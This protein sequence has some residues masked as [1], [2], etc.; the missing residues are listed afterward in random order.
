MKQ[1]LKIITNKLLNK[2]LKLSLA[3]LMIFSYINHNTIQNVNAVTLGYQSES[4][5]EKSVTINDLW[6]DSSSH[7]YK[8]KMGGEYGFCLDMGQRFS[9]GKYY[10]RNSW[11]GVRESTTVKKIMNWFYRGSKSDYHFWLAQTAIWGIQ[12]GKITNP[13]DDFQKIWTELDKV[14][15]ALY[16]SLAPGDTVGPDCSDMMNASSEGSFYIYTY[17][18]GYQRVASNIKGEIPTASGKLVFSTKSYSTT[19]QIQLNINKTDIDTNNVLS[20]VEFELYR[21]NTKIANVKTNA[22]GKASH[23]FE[24]EY[25]KTATA[26][27]TYCDNYD[28]LS[29]KNKELIGEVDYTSRNAAQNAADKEA[30]DKAKAEVQKLLD[31][32]HSYKAVE[33]KTKTAYYLDTNNNTW[34]K[35]YASGD[36]S[37]S[38]S[39]SVTNKRQ[40]G[41]ISI[42][43]LDSETGHSVSNAIYGLYAKNPIVHPDGHTGTLYAKDELVATFPATA[44]NG[45]ATLNNLYLGDY[46]VKEITAPNGYVFNTKKY[47]VTLSYAGQEISVTDES[48]NVDDKVQR[49]SLSFVKKD[50]ELVNGKDEN[51]FDSN[52]DG[53]QGDATRQHATYGLYA[54]ENIVHSDGTT[55]IVQYNQSSGSINEIKLSKGTDLSVKNVRANAGVLLATAKTDRNGEIQFDHLYNGKYYVKEIE[56]SEGYL[57]DHTE[58]DFDL[59]YTNQSEA[60]IKKDGTVLETVKKQAFEVLKVGHVSGSSTVVPPLE[61]VEF[62]VKLESDVVRLGWDNAPTY[63]ILVTDEKGHARSIELPSGTY[64]VKETKPAL[65]YD[66]CEDF[67]VTISEDSRT[68]QS[69]TNKII[70]DEAF[71]A[72]IKAVKLDK[73]TGKTVMLPDTTFKIKALSDVVVDGKSFKAGEYIGY[74]NWNILDG[75]YTDTWKTNEQGYVMIN[76]KLSV[77]E[78]QLEEIHAPY[79]YILD[80]TPVKFKVTNSMMIETGKDNLTPVIT[81]YKSDVPIKGQVEI[82]KKGE[83]L[84][85][86]DKT[87]GFIYEERYLPDMKVG[88]YAEEDILD[89]SNDGTILYQ[90]DEL[91]ETLITGENG[92]ITSSNLPLG[93]YYSKEIQAPNGFVLSDEIMHF[94]LKYVDENTSIVFENTGFVN[95]RQKI[96]LDLMKYD[97]DKEIV[98]SGAEMTMF[99]NKDIL[100]YDGDVIVAKGEAI[101]TVISNEKGEII[102]D[103]DLPMYCLDLDIDEGEFP[104]PFGFTLEKDEEGDIVIG[105]EESLFYVKETKQPDGYVEHHFKYMIDTA[106]QGQNQENITITYDIY[107]EKA[108]GDIEIKKADSLDTSKVMK[109]VEFN[110]SSDENM[111]NIIATA[112]TDENSTARFEDM[113]AGRY[114]IQEAKQVDGYVLND[115]I[116]EVEITTEGEVLTIYVEN[117]PTE[118]EFSKVDE[119]GVNE[120]EGAEVTVID[121]ATNEVVDEWVSGKEPHKINYLVEG[122]EYIFKEDKAPLGYK[123][124]EEIR[125]VAGDGKTVTMKDDLILT[126]IQVNKVDAQTKK[127]IVSEDF[128]FTMYADKGLTQV[129]DVVCANTKDGTATFENVKPLQTVYIKETK[130]PMGYKLSDEVKEIV[131]DEHLEG[132]G[133]IHSFIYTN[134]LLPVIKTQTGDNSMIEL[135]GILSLSGIIGVILFRRKKKEN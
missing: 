105:N 127:A 100:N 17:E 123:V 62:T 115:K 45:K 35:E 40:L 96:K 113:E 128:E 9:G 130:A 3:L 82:Y 119:T 51:I 19:D 74:W 72:L 101:Q 29:P 63:D 120:L 6:G 33:T 12:K 112:K 116:Y 109:D 23:T 53:A 131:I 5:L 8:L 99:A 10:D 64:R 84:T 56:A 75:F 7:T 25:S 30:L 31:E 60:V 94:E 26:S 121:T 77:G 97:A 85:G 111:S 22:E 81:V 28:E 93:K 1:K 76:E 44:T 20:N 92:K 58:Y 52:H 37:G 61:G 34:T 42:T 133:D 36:G 114:Y 49:A 124:A 79:G 73:E 47:D 103:L 98:L 129:L 88:I 107:N 90:K 135:F 106:Y 54:R 132:Y 59:S 46:Y 126:D 89:P 4:S 69:F 71:S 41:S 57:L 15:M 86:Y 91:I 13:Y 70:V 68:P 134:S 24:K 110:I 65:D 125:F 87:K 78:Y 27:A 55:G 14:Y 118:M 80:E 67:F 48:I 32:K 102:F 16:G 11:S 2:L 38:V 83:V 66:A 18:S 104:D 108:R 122:K 95:E 43:K 21:D 50:R 117:K 39:F